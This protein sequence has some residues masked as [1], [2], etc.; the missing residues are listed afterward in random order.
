MNANTT[1]PPQYSNDEDSFDEDITA[2]D[3]SDEEG[4]KAG[5]FVHQEEHDENELDDEEEVFGL[6]AEITPAITLPGSQPGWFPPM[7]P[8]GFQY[9]PK[10][11]ALA[12]WEEVDNPGGWSPYTF[13][14]RYDKKVY[15][16]HSHWGTGL[17]SQSKQ[18]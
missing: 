17:S 13:Q 10:W 12:S 11:N 1:Q 18:R 16:G 3:D 8:I 6:E 4:D 15:T 5:L 2:G 14:A 9:Q 7:P